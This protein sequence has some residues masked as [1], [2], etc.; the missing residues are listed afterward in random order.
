MSIRANFLDAIGG[1]PLMRLTGIV[2]G[3]HAELLG[4]LERF[5]PTGSVK[6]RAAFAMIRDAEQ[7][8]RLSSDSVI[9]EAT[10]GNTGIALACMAAARGYRAII[11]MPDAVSPDKVRHIRAYGAEVVFTPA[12][13]GMKRAFAEAR[14]IAEKLPNAFVPDQSRNPANPAIHRATTGKEIWDDTGGK[15]DVFVAGVGTGGTLTGVAECLREKNPR[16]EIVAVEPSGS[17]VL[18]RGMAGPHRIEGIGAGFVPDVLRR[19]LIDRIETVSDDEALLTM[20]TL[21][22]RLGVF[23]G[24]SSGAALHAALRL[25]RDARYHGKTIVTVLPDSGDR[26]PQLNLSD[27]DQADAVAGVSTGAVQEATKC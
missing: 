24:P 27:A 23:A 15:V 7:R 4:K 17:P 26:Y 5:N 21:A 1:T 9:V 18:S 14:R 22:R 16:V 25:A 12:V 10:S 11:V 20:Q 13:F 2:A 19:E 3:L 6:D 8:G